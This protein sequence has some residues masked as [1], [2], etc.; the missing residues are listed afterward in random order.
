MPRRPMPS[1]WRAWGLAWVDM[2]TGT[3]KP[4]EGVVT[5][6]NGKATFTVVEG[7]ATG[8]LVAITATY[9]TH[10]TYALMNPALPSRWSPAT[11][12]PWS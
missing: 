6:E 11:C 3:V 9:H 8:R 7:A 10:T 5:D 1:L 2:A 4:I 12:I